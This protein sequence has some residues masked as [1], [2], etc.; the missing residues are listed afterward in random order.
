MKVH[1]T[2]KQ[3]VDQEVELTQAQQ[4]EGV[5]REDQVRLFREAEDCR[6]GVERKHEVG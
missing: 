4:G 5:A 3:S 6:N 2:I 1:E